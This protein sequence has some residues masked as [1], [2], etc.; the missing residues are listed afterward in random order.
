VTAPLEL[1]I[2]FDRG[3]AL[4]K[5]EPLEMQI[6]PGTFTIMFAPSD[7][8]VI[9][10]YYLWTFGQVSPAGPT[11]RLYFYHWQEGVKKHADPMVHSL[12]DFEYKIWAWSSKANPHY[13]E[14]HNETGEIQTVDMQFWMGVFP[15]PRT[16]AYWY[17]DLILLGLRNDVGDYILKACKMSREEFE[18]I[19]EERRKS[20]YRSL[21]AGLLEQ[22]LSR[23]SH[24]PVPFKR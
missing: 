3:Y 13:I 18:K 20:C 1:R 6:P 4:F 12:I 22:V 15:N 9:W 2:A 11:S 19:L 8:D 23:I 16:Y 17:A 5:H 10:Q 7:P 21:E 14:V 24:I